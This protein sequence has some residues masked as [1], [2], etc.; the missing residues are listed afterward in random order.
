MMPDT[1]RERDQIMQ[2]A[3]VLLF[4][5]LILPGCTATGT[6]PPASKPTAT[7]ACKSDGLETYVGKKAN[8]QSGAELVAKSG[9]RALRWAPP[10]SA[11]TMDYREDRLTVAYDDDM[12]ITSARCG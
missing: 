1:D 11:M 10:R 8:Q 12:T 6:P 9:A 4:A 3:A 5:C 2:P 7:G